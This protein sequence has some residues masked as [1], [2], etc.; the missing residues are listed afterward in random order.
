V[1]ETTQARNRARLR[2]FQFAVVGASAIAAGLFASGKIAVAQGLGAQ[3]ISTEPTVNGLD[4]NYGVVGNEL[5]DTAAVTGSAPDLQ[6]Q[7]VDFQLFGPDNPYCTV[8]GGSTFLAEWDVP[9]QSDGTA[10]TN[11]TFQATTQGGYHWKAHLDSDLVNS[12]GDS[13]CGE[14]TTIG[15]AGSDIS[16]KPSAGGVVGTAISDWAKVTGWNPTGDVWFMLY[17]PSDASCQGTA[18]QTVEANL[19]ADGTA[20]S[21]GT[22]FTTKAVGTYHWI[23][24]YEGDTNNTPNISKCGDE[25]AVITATPVAQTVTSTPPS[26]VTSAVQSTTVTVPATGAASDISVRLVL[27]FLVLGAG[28]ML[29]A[30]GELVYV[31]SRRVRA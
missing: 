9:L 29:A 19:A 31:R 6:T 28:L 13:A 10:S 18:V 12:G 8:G 5:G 3:S 30:V 20:S 15:I 2:K 23:V 1:G 21:S 22:P 24:R 4:R 27:A 25:W 14:T 7:T 26:H 11:S 16:S 17:P